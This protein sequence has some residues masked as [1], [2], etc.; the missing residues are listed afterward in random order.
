M[1]CRNNGALFVQRT[2]D[3]SAFFIAL[4][5]VDVLAGLADGSSGPYVV[6][7]LVDQA[8]LGPLAL[9][10][11][12]T[13]RALGGIRLCHRLWG[14]DRQ[15]DER[16]ALAPR[17]RR[18]SARLRPAR[19]YNRFRR[20]ARLSRR[21]RWRSGGLAFSQSIALVNGISTTRTFTPPIAPSASW[22]ASR[23]LAWA[24]GPAIGAAVVEAF[25]FRG[26]FFTSA[27]SGVVALMALCPCAGAAGVRQRGPWRS[28]KACE[29]RSGDRARLHWPCLVSHRFVHGINSAGHCGD[30]VARRHDER[31]RSDVQLAALRLKS[32][33]WARS[34]GDRSGAP[35]GRRLSPA[36][37][38]LWP[39]LSRSRWRGRSARCFGP[40]SSGRS[41]SV[42]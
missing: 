21:S 5:V 37:P 14:V 22:R 3:R 15:K 26:A 6:L 41:R 32:W 36:S 31:C 33:L 10:A 23:S 40:K 27:G 24:F 7:F 28:A 19:L 13:A 39:I 16:Q 20:P 42:S 2:P 17:S 8:R 4:V 30:D 11:V 1:L 35:S 29:R 34:S 18:A 38:S 12:L 25:G 9:S